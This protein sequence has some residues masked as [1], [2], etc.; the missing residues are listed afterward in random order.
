MTPLE[1]YKFFARGVGHAL[2]ILKDV[3]IDQAV[4]QI[5]K[6]HAFWVSLV[7]KEKENE[8]VS[9]KGK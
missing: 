5:E 3:P 7:E 1:E 6:S 8:D 2:K 9:N 4:E